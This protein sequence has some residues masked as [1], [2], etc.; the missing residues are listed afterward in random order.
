MTYK[1]KN[2]YYRGRES[3]WSEF[4]SFL[5][6]ADVSQVKLISSISK[7]KQALLTASRFLLQRRFKMKKLGNGGAFITRVE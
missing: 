5:R 2:V 1:R 7:Q 3:D 4:V 6:D